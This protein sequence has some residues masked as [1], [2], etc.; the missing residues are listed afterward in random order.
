MYRKAGWPPYRKTAAINSHFSVG[1]NLL[2]IKAGWAQPG[3]DS[4]L[5]CRF[6][7]LKNRQAS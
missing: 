1:V 2:I 5:N 6:G 3:I 7:G 4:A